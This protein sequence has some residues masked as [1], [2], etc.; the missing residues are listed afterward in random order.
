MA[1]LEWRPVKDWEGRYDV[2]SQGDVRSWFYGVK[3]LDVPRLLTPKIDKYGYRVVSLHHKDLKKSKTV[4]RLVAEAFIPN[5]GALPH[6]N[7]LDGDKQNNNVAN[8]KW[9]TGRE[10]VNHAYESGLISREK[11]SLSQA[12]RYDDP[13]ERE[14]QR[15]VAVRLWDDEEF[16]SKQRAARATADYRRAASER[17]KEQ[18]PPTT[19]TRRINNGASEKCVQGD[20]LNTYIDSGWT[21]G[22]LSRK[23]QV[24]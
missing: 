12:K 15:A 4:H 7:H 5:P 18:R 16:R 10:N 2:S 24:L 3:H 8:L 1:P 6:I 17:R 9:C 13:A 11:M 22:R 21:L 23:G 14:R 19:G 20:L